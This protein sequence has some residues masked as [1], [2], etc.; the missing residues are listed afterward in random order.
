MQPGEII[1]FI[2][3][4]GFLTALVTRVKA[5]K[6]LLLTESNREMSIA[7]SRVLHQTSLGLDLSLPRAELVRSLKEISSRRTSLA[8]K[9]NLFE[10]WELL[11]GEGEEFD[12]RYLAELALPPPIGPDQVAAAL[13]AVFANGLHFKMRPQ[14]ARRHSATR[15]E[16]I[17]QARIQEEKRERE[18]K[19]GGAWLARIWA[20]ETPDDPACRDHVVKT[21]RDM[22]LYGPEAAEYKWG[23]KLLER[24]DLGKDPFRPFY[25]L[26]KIGEMDRHE[27]LDLLRLQIETSFPEKVQAAAAALVEQADLDRENRRNLTDLDTLT[28][29]SSGSEDFDDAVSL[30]E[31]GG[32]SILG[33]H[34]ADVSAIIQPDSP[35][36]L[37]ARHLATSIYMPDR[38]ISMLP[39]VLSDQA[40]SL[41]EGS[42]RPAFSVL[43]QIDEAGQVDSFE[44]FPSLVKIKRRLSYQEV[45]ETVEKDPTLKKLLALSQA[46]KAQRHAQGALIMPLPALSVYLAPEGQ[47]GI[48]LIQWDNPGRAMIT[49]FMVLAN[50]LAARL[51]AEAGAPGLYRYQDEPSQR[52]IQGEF[53]EVGL[54]DCLKQ[55]RFLNRVGWSL[56]PRPHHGMGLDVYTNLTSPLRRFID[57]IIQRQVK[58]LTAGERPYYLSEQIGELLTLIEPALK[59]AHNV[60]FR[61]KRYWLL[62]YLEAQ[63]PKNFEAILLDVLPNRT[64]VFVKELMLELDLTD[65]SAQKLT[66]GQEVMIKIK[67]VNARQDILKF[68]L[69]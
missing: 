30:E 40:L 7:S 39:E 65:R 53:S 12:Y 51:L 63:S 56:E 47:I 37:E 28:I 66:P 29:D 26:V 8:A 46:L 58:S 4:R 27:N 57:L 22:A 1:E 61:R 67:K 50:H 33:I 44:F 59:K 69:V 3:N 45:D 5:S 60:Q 49:E 23:Q 20:D 62:R 16:Q 13:R 41:K 19:E 6:L 24:A 21:L 42:I 34:I 43:A 32:R 11:E 10:L 38:R 54:Y 25:L 9:V 52:I 48:S 31:Q 18:L 15:V 64:R 17:E 36:E 55:R 35:L 2:E 14:S 68:E